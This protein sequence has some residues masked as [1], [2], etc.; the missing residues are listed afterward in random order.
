MDNKKS[1]QFF[2]TLDNSV[3]LKI[4][5]LAAKRG[6]TTQDFIRAVMI[7]EWFDNEKQKKS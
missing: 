3:Y 5:R 4:K 1:T 6:I 2:M 7:P